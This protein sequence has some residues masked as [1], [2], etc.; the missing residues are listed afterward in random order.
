MTNIYRTT[1]YINATRD[2]YKRATEDRN[3]IGSEFTKKQSKR[4]SLF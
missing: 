2:L 3:R 1:F 4:F